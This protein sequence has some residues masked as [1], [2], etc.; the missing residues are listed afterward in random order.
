MHRVVGVPRQVELQELGH[1]GIVH[2]DAF[3]AH[4]SMRT[5]DTQSPSFFSELP[6]AQVSSDFS[7]KGVHFVF[8]MEE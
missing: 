2:A 6:E 1:M 8:P 5:P 4:S 3:L 7:L